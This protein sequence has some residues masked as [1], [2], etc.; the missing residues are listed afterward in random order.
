M[1]I[2]TIAPTALVSQFGMGSCGISDLTSDPDSPDANYCDPSSPYT[3]NGVRVSFPTPAYSPKTGA[4]I[5]TFRVEFRRYGTEGSLPPHPVITVALRE[6]SGGSNLDEQTFNVP[7]DMNTH[8]VEFTW[9]ASLLANPNGAGVE[10]LAYSTSASGSGNVATAKVGGIEW[11]STAI[12]Q[13][14]ADIYFNAPRPTISADA[15]YTEPVPVYSADIAFNAPRPT[16]SADARFTPA[17]YHADIAFD[18]PRPTVFAAAEFLPV[19][20]TTGWIGP[21]L[22]IA[23]YPESGVTVS[24]TSNM[25]AEDNSLA[26]MVLQTTGGLT[27]QTNKSLMWERAHV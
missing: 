21:K 9:D 17:Q 24:N 23:Q 8:V 25:A 26:S 13:H 11:E 15:S 2:Q 3:A 19:T 7:A 12:S 16:I 27:T 14:H 4:D 20:G 10:C 22:P 6:T 5:Q 18:A 1:A